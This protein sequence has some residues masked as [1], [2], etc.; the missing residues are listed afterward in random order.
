MFEKY[1]NTDTNQTEATEKSKP[2]EK[3]NDTNQVETEKKQEPESNSR[4][5]NIFARPGEKTTIKQPKNQTLRGVIFAL[6]GFQNPERAEIR[7]RGLKLGAK[8]R[9]DWTDDCTHL[10]Y[11]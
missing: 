5:P 8:Y 4:K 3:E 9:P 11:V 7:D 6:S 2:T 10:V 1:K